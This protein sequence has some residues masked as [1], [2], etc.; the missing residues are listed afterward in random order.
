MSALIRSEL[1]GAVKFWVAAGVKRLGGDS[2]VAGPGSSISESRFLSTVSG[3]PRV[4][5]AT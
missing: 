4:F 3:N 5:A 2:G 1:F